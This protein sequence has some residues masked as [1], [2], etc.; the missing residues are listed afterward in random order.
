MLTHKRKLLFMFGLCGF[1]PTFIG[2]SIDLCLPAIGKEFNMTIISLSWI[3]TA[4]ILSTAVLVIPFGRLADIYGRRK[5]FLTGIIFFT[6]TT[7][8]CSIASSGNLLIAIR[9]LQGIASAMI[10]GTT[11]A[12]L[13]TIFPSRERGRALGISVA[14]VYLGS[15]LGPSVGGIL[16]QYFGWR[17]IFA[18]TTFLGL[19]TIIMSIKYLTNEWIDAHGET[20]DIVGSL[21]YGTSTIA[22]LYG[23]TKIPA[24]TGYVFIATGIV[25]FIIFC[26]IKDY[27]KHPVFDINLLLKNKSFAMS[28]L[29]ALLNFSA[30]F[31]VPFLM[32]LYLQ[33]IKGIPPQTAG[34]IILASPITMVI[35]SPI[36]GKLSDSI[37]P[38]TIASIG[39][40]CSSTA[41]LIMSFIITPVT[42]CYV[43]M[44]LFFVFGTGI[45]FFA[46]PNT[47]AAMGVVTQKQL[48]AAGSI[49]NSMRLFGQT[50]SMGIST[51]ML[52]VFVGKVEITRT[53]YPQLMT[54]IRLTL[55][56]FGIFCFLGIFV[57]LARGPR[58]P[59]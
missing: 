54:S 11:T 20:F 40:F 33:Y 18:T 41:L 22:L 12:L 29:A 7:L 38:R 39:M 13:V 23:T 37:D 49:L 46:T 17:S 4:Y 31:S 1:L 9:A 25:L 24:I 28:N 50:I 19:I 5:I 15:S 16:T 58:Q 45:S 53:V 43:I 3:I 55:I 59:E 52:S 57:S 8:L 35:G 51:L 2:R 48:G 47:N 42:P 44:L 6:I 27:I 10:F 26:I 21:L 56:I 34:F 36:A 32:S 14:G 30:A